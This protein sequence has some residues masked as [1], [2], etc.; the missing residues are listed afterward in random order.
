AA[1]VPAIRKELGLSQPEFAGFMGVSLGT[2]RN[3]EQERREPQ[4]PARALLLVASKQ[5]AAVL[6][7][8]EAA[9]P[10]VRG[11]TRRIAATKLAPQPH[12]TSVARRRLA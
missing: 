11:G 2:L 3:W 9:K 4:G 6:A 8:L 10:V 12:A 7:A 1:D 5:P